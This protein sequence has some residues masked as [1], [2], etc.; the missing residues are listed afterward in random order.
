MALGITPEVKT[1]VTLQKI[2]HPNLMLDCSFVETRKET[3]Q[4]NGWYVEFKSMQHALS[5]NF[6]VG[7]R[8]R[9]LTS[10]KV[11]DPLVSTAKPLL[12]SDTLNVVN[13]DLLSHNADEATD[14]FDRDFSG[15]N[16]FLALRS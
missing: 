5:G 1:T 10:Q 16:L 12:K 14:F 6:G 8:K 3:I 7:V 2:L 4:A 15:R 9:A 11:R 13:I